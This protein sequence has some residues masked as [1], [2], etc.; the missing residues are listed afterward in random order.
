MK[1]ISQSKALEMIQSTR[2]SGKIFSA[3][4]VKKDG[5]TRHMTCRLNVKK[6]LKGG[7]LKFNPIERGMIPVYDMQK[8]QYRMINIK[9]L[10][11]LQIN[12]QVY[13]VGE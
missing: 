13:T 12:K 8:E 1:I 6:H 4:F 11:A 2:D 5:T 3:A 10:K 9:T 7:E